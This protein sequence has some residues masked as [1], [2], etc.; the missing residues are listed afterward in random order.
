MTVRPQ[1]LI[2]TGRRFVWQVSNMFW[3]KEKTPQG[4]AD[5]TTDGNDDGLGS[6]PLQSQPEQV[7]DHLTRREY[8]LSG[9]GRY[10]LDPITHE[11]TPAGKS[12]RLKHRLNIAI[13]VLVVLIIV[14]YLILF[15]L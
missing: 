9:K 2:C 12:A 10:E 14:T 5:Y 4:P 15:L 11:L 8:R 7:N 6:V 3:R 13:I 1:W